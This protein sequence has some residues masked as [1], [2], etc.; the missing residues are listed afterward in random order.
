MSAYNELIA[1]CNDKGILNVYENGVKV[2]DA[3]PAL[4]PANIG[5]PGGALTTFSPTTIKFITQYMAGDEALGGRQQLLPFENDDYKIPSIEYTGRVQ[6]Y[7]DYDDAYNSG[8]NVNFQTTGHYVFST[9]IS[10]GDRLQAQLA[11]VNVDLFSETMN[12]AASALNIELNRVAF[13]GYMGNTNHP[14]LV[15]GLLNHPDLGAYKQPNPNKKISQMS[16]DELATFFNSAIQDLID[17]TGNNMQNTSVRCVIA[18]KAFQAMN[19]KMSPYQG[20]S[21]PTAIKENLKGL[22]VELDFVSAAELNGAN[23]NQDV[24]YFI[25][26]TSL[27]GALPTSILGYSE[28]GRLSRVVYGESYMKQKMSSGTTGAIIY[29][30]AFIV[31]YTNI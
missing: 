6:S 16:W 24:C 20:L 9:A 17:Q 2:N 21:V 15:R 7:D 31:R 29:K 5:L 10:I 12:A 13:N 19:G 18:S 4:S 1:K 14:F 8:I 28:L 30:P 27:G 23:A 25:V 26:E 11:K 22:K 3:L